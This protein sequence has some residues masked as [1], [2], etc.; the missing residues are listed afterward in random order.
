[1]SLDSARQQIALW[2]EDYRRFVV[3]NFLRPD[4]RIEPFQEEAL[5]AASGE[6]KLTLPRIALKASKGPGKTTTIAWLAWACMATRPHFNGACISITGE[7]LRDNLWKEL[8]KWQNRSP[9]LKKAFTWN[10]TRVFANDHEA[11]WWLSA[12]TWP[13]NGDANAQS[14][15]LAGLH[16]EQVG[17]F[18]DETG[19]YPSAVMATAD[20]VLSSCKWGI[21]VQAGN[22]TH[23]EGPLYD[24]VTKHRQMWRVITING[25]PDNPKRAT[26]VDVDWARAQIKAYG[27]D[28]PFV[29]VNVFGEFPPA[30][31]NTLLGPDEVERAMTRYGAI[32]ESQF[33]WAQKRIGCD[34]ARFGDDPNVFFPRQGVMALNPI[35]MRNQ[36]GPIL[37]AR[38]ATMRK[39]W[40]GTPIIF[41]DDTGGYGAT[42]E[43]NLNTAGIA[44]IP[45]NHS[46]SAI[47]PRYENKRAE[48]WWNMAE[49]VK[50]HGALPNVPELVAELTKTH[51]TFTKKGRLILE[52]KDI[53]KEAIGHSPNFADALSLTFTLPEAPDLDTEDGRLLAAAAG[54][55]HVEHDWDP[56]E[57]Q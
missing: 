25:D 56:T 41:I 48:N 39:R 43:D 42:L 15:A 52:S 26:R 8:A 38:V 23:L 28:N 21:V 4:E 27:R 34:V 10:K 54:H 12:R 30:S 18:A 22:P 46:S 45:V 17:V 31:I 49:W 37:A 19:G 50:L 40:G 5:L 1:M 51:Y 35:V 14:D 11:T 32:M 57:N 16:A 33:T 3:D 36:R 53:I 9:F 29:M 20:A 55:G 7:N 6:A 47:D 13:K 24:A 2:R 44:Y